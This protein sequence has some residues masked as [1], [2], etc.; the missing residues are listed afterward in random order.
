[1]PGQ[2]NPNGVRG[3][4]KGGN[5][6]SCGVGG[7][8]VGDS[9]N[10]G[11]ISMDEVAVVFHSV[12]SGELRDKW[13]AVTFRSVNSGELRGG[14]P[15]NLVSSVMVRVVVFLPSVMENSVMGVLGSGGSVFC[16]AY[17]GD[18]QDG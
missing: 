3:M 18:P 4:D 16:S 1:M 8:N 11:D 9:V 15:F 5:F 13:V 6:G 2:L 17:S 7:L 10:F 12:S 14:L